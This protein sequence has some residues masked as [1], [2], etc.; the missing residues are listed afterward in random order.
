LSQFIDASDA[1]RH[2]V[3]SNAVPFTI[4]WLA[5]TGMAFVRHGSGHY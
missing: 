3:S 5:L 1:A 2:S 4:E